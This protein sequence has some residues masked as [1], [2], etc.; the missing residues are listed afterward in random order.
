MTL[1][2]FKTTSVVKQTGMQV[3]NEARGF[4]TIADEP[5]NLGGTDTGMSPTE[6]LLCALGA[7]QCMTARFFAGTLKI[8]LEEFRVDIEGDLDIMGF[9]KGDSGIR[10]GFQE[11]R[12][13]VHIRTTAP[14]EKI[15]EL[16]ALVES[17]GP[18]NDTILHGTRV[19]V[20][21]IVENG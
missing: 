12:S 8:E 7:C 15:A 3:E 5:K 4:K 11:I 14:Q 6:T 17:R 1:H 19:V 9:L 21:H 20:R 10:P 13:T 16:M 2:T 18:V